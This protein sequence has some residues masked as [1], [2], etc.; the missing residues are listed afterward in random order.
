MKNKNQKIRISVCIGIGLVLLST[1]ALGTNT[2]VNG[3][4]IVPGTQPVI[5]SELI[6]GQS[7]T[8]AN[9]LVITQGNQY[10]FR[11]TIDA[12]ISVTDNT[13]VKLLVTDIITNK[14][15]NADASVIG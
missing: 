3:S 15:Y 11:G 7:G 10:L 13:D 2:I 6:I 1:L 5:E 9:I 4:G 8:P 12:V 14:Q